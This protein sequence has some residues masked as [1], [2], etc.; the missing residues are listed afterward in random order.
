MAALY[1]SLSQVKTS[2]ITAEEVR[3]SNL[4][5]QDIQFEELAVYLALTIEREGMARW[6]IEHC[7]PNRLGDHGDPKSLSSVINR[8]MSNWGCL[9]E[10]CR[11]GDRKNMLAAMPQVATLFVNANELLLVIPNTDHCRGQD[12]TKRTRG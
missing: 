10:H 4:Y 5:F 6:N 8:N 9:T 2:I 11:E 1:P 7:Y 3:D 12:V